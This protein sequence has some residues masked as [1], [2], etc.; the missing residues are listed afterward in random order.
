MVLHIYD[1]ELLNGIAETAKPDT[2]VQLVLCGFDTN[3]TRTIYH[4]DTGPV[5]RRA[6]FATRIS[7]V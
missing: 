1:I 5:E 2:N 4:N 7:L 3:G 6:Y